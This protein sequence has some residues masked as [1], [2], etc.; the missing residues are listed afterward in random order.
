M[1][2]GDQ[3]L[4]WD[5]EVKVICAMD[6]RTRTERQLRSWTSFRYCINLDNLPPDFLLHEANKFLIGFSQF[7]RAF[8]NP[9]QM[10]SSEAA[11]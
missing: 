3:Q 1:M 6:A 10:Q 7:G 8:W 11:H 2:T 9:T 4:S 5:C